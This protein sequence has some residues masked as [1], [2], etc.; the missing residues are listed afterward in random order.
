[1][2]VGPAI[3][4]GRELGRTLAEGVMTIEE[5]ASGEEVDRRVVKGGYA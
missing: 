5:N 2:M 4:F 1:M 3:S